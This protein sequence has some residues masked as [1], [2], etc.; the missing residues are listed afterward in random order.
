MVFNKLLCLCG[1]IVNDY[2]RLRKYEA[3]DNDVLGN[4]HE[5]VHKPYVSLCER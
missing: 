2:R 1:E 5:R 4:A 3:V